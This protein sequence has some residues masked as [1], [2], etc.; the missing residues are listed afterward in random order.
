M[1]IA[2]SERLSAEDWRLIQGESKHTTICVLFNAYKK[3]KTICLIFSVTILDGSDETYNLS[4]WWSEIK[5]QGSMITVH[6]EG[7]HLVRGNLRGTVKSKGFILWGAWMSVQDLLQIHW[8]DIQIF[9]TSWCQNLGNQIAKDIWIHPVS[10][11][12]K[13]FLFWSNSIVDL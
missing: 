10:K 11:S 2:Q 6:P 9:T 5:S 13:I 7:K 12:V 1:S 3:I 8:V 4:W